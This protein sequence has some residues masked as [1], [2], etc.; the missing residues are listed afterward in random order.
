MPLDTCYKMQYCGLGI[1]DSLLISL[2]DLLVCRFKITL[3][4]Q[5]LSNFESHCHITFQNSISPK[6]SFCRRFPALSRL[7]HNR[8]IA[9]EV[10]TV[11][12][13]VVIETVLFQIEAVDKEI[14]QTQ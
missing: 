5:L 4:M 12:L 1:T 14:S 10:H 9:G 2:D 8:T 3:V 13:N 7:C 11:K 6:H